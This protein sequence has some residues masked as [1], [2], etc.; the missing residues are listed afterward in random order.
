VSLDPDSGAEVG[1]FPVHGAAEVE[2]AVRS[3]R[4]A[5]VWWGELGFDGRRRR[6][7]R[8]AGLM[9]SRI[10]EIVDLIHRENGKPATDA[11]VE[12]VIALDHLR[13]AATHAGR[14]LGEHRVASGLLALNHASSIEYQP[15][16]VIGVIGPWNYPIHTPMG[17]ISYAL[18]AG[19][20]VVFKPSE[21][22]PGIGRWI[23]DRIAEAV[24]EQPVIQ[25]VTGFGPTGEALC[26]SGVDKL[27]FTGSARTGRRVMSACADTLTPVLMEC[28]GNDALVVDADAD[29][30]AAAKAAVWGS[31]SNAGQ[32]CVSVERAYV[33]DAVFDRFVQRVTALAGAVRAG[34]GD[35]ADIGPITMPAQV[36]I[37]R[38][39]VEDALDRGARAVVG[40]RQ[41]VRPPYVDPVVLV[42]V[43]ADALMLREE[44]FGPVLPILRVRDADDAIRLAN[45]GRYGLASAV[46][47][48][49]RAREIARRLRSGMTSINSVLVFAGVPNLPFGGSGESGFGRIHG[50]DGLKEFT[51]AKAV[52]RLRF[53]LP[54]DVMAFGN[55]PAVAR[56]LR[57]V[58]RLRHRRR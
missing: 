14:V 43:P 19:N 25:L 39:H 31:L 17:S 52:T 3:A 46:F 8:V 22:T 53:A 9:S 48:K 50:A 11:L 45:E 30:E 18:A 15:L 38:K 29:V 49:R 7:L 21:F 44:T 42:D 57:L 35:T 36:D 56:G 55:P 28:G 13:W 40:G 24:P 41:S 37:I 47:G 54:I 26:R 6:L 2:A 34:G 32:A 51:R 10:D 12:V 27:A 16:G 20:A 33:V 58:T 23:V 5:A 4:Q 1:R